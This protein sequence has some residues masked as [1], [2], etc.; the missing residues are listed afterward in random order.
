MIIDVHAYLDQRAGRKA[1][2]ASVQSFAEKCGVDTFL[3][4]NLE[5]APSAQGGGGLDETTANLAC[6]TACA[7]CPSLL[8]LY[9]VRPG[10]PGSHVSVFAGA[11]GTEPFLGAVFFA[12]LDSPE[13]TGGLAALEPYLIALRKRG[14]PALFPVEAGGLA[15]VG[16]IAGLARR[17]SSIPFVLLGAGR[18]RDWAKAIDEVRRVVRRGEAAL[19]LD[20]AYARPADIAAAVAD[21]GPER[22]L[23]GSGGTM[24]YREH[25]QPCRAVLEQLR[26]RLTPADFEKLTCGNA[27]QLFRIPKESQIP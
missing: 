3:V 22:L 25:A 9:T 18:E 15:A 1:D 4:S 7:I 26:D 2:P 6:L 14:M 8:P 10:S 12:A 5:A 27:R 24:L 16:K 19:Y 13:P 21:L 20:T 17:F 11:L 23:F